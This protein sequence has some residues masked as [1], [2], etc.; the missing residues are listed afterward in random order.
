M[1]RKEPSP[2]DEARDASNS[3]GGWTDMMQPHGLH[4]YDDDD[5]QEAANIVEAYGEADRN[6]GDTGSSK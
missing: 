5:V 2:S 6:S 3:Y 4:A 1:R